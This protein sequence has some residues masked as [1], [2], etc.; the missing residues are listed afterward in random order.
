MTTKTRKTTS[1]PTSKYNPMSIGAIEEDYGIVMSV[2]DKNMMLSDYF[3]KIGF[4]IHGKATKY[5]EHPTVT[6]K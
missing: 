6:A 1:S 4:P 3:T 2:S 5:S